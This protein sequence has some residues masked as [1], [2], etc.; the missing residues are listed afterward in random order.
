MGCFCSLFYCL[1]LSHTLNLSP[2][3]TH[4]FSLSLPL[5]HTHTLSRSHTYTLSL[6]LTHSL[7]H[8]HSLSLS[9]PPSLSLSHRYKPK[10]VI[11]TTDPEVILSQAK[12]ILNK[13]SV[14]NF[15][16][17]SDQFMAVGVDS[18]E[19]MGKAIELIVVCAQMNEHFSFMYAELCRKITDKWS[20]GTAEE[21]RVAVTEWWYRLTFIMC[22]S[23]RT[24][25]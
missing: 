12:S 14:T 6:S 4:F 13:L 7:S 1:S 8:T 25:V 22:L 3:Q 9:P 5:S 24:C 19:L 11:D 2:K 21:V 10:K 15:D 18:K 17:L 16:K 23:K 20:T